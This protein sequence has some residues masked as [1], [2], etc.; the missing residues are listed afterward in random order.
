MRKIYTLFFVLVFFVQYKSQETLPYY[1]QYLLEGDF[2]FNPALYGKTDDVVLNLNYQKQF[3][4]FA[5]S[6]NVQSIGLHAN[7]FDR[8][9]AGLSFFRDQNGPVSSNGIGAGASYFIPIDDDGERKSQFS[10][11]TNVNF[12]NMNIDLGKLNP[13]DPGDPTLASD[14][15]SL[16]LVYANLGMAV[17]FRNFFAGVSVNDIALT[18]DIPI[19]N[20][21]EPEPTKFILNAGYDYYLTEQ[22]YVSPSVLMNFNTNSSR[23]TD[24]NLMATILGEENSFSAGASFRTSKNQFGSQ[25]LGISPILKATVNNFFFGASYN[26]GLSDIQQYAGSSF[27]LSVGYNIENF[28]NTRGYRY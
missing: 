25:N 28:I 23:I 15:N 6:P 8:V 18:N 3:S 21:I 12:Y 20:G 27:M 16:F 11:G 22:F 1:Q 13:Q 7:I 17:T 10:F 5:E 4:Q 24:M 19:V 2:L 26:F 9:G 14:T